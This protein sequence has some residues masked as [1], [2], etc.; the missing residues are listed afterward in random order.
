MPIKILGVCG[1]PVRD[2]NTELFLNE[3][4]GAAEA[5]G[6]E[7]EAINL[8]G[9]EVGDCIHCNWCLAKQEED[10]Y[11]SLDDDMARL[12]PKVLAADGLVLAT[13]VYLGRLSG[14]L[15]AFLDRLRALH[16]GR[17]T[18]GAMKYK[19]GAALA[20]AWYR[21][22][23]VETALQSLHLAFL[24]FQMLI[25]VPGSLCTFGG[26]GLASAGGGGEFDKDIRHGVAEDIIGLKTARATGRALVELCRLIEKGRA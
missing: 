1:S 17:R 22:S 5:D 10:R 25:A 20:V 8:A 24:T 6:V 4:L 2:S 26:G 15:A 13:P 11:C 18:L 14:H 7:V 16:Y 19:A 21:H 9:L 3:A 12:Y 23:G